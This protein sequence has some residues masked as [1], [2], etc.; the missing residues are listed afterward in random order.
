MDTSF[1]LEIYRYFLINENNTDYICY[2]KYFIIGVCNAKAECIT[3]VYNSSCSLLHVY[4]YTQILCS[5]ID[6]KQDDYSYRT[7]YFIIYH[8]FIMV[9]SWPPSPPNACVCRSNVVPFP[10]L[11]QFTSDDA[12]CC[13]HLVDDAIQAGVTLTSLYRLPP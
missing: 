6:I 9:S 5:C 10:I 13:K 3:K 4:A 1:L 11:S 12:C 8:F 2:T 7:L